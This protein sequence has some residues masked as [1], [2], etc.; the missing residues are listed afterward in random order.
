M[1]SLI[2]AET[3]VPSIHE[4]S[5]LMKQWIQKQEEMAVLNAEVKQR[6]TQSKALRDMI[7]RIMASNKIST[8]NV[9]KGAVVH[10]VREVRERVSEDY[11][12]KHCKEFFQG[13]EEK[14]KALIT[15]LEEHRGT[16]VK[17]DLKILTG[18]NGS[19]GGSSH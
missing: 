18:S 3:G 14:A 13:D 15:Y 7:L 8:L 12:M 9:S 19:D 17:H 1:S 6:R 11:L 4:L 10:R 16:A 5:G 2:S